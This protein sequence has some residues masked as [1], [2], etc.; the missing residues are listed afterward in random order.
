MKKIRALALAMALFA[1]LLAR[2]ALAALPGLAESVVVVDKKANQIH[3]ANY[4]E[5]RLDVLKSYRATIGKNGGDKLWE[6]DLKTPEGIYDFLY[7]KTPPAL[8]KKFG[9]LAIY[10]GYPNSMDRHGSKTGFDI[11]LHGTDDPS[12]L[13]RPFDSLGCVVTDNVNV[14]EISDQIKLKDTKVIITKDFSP[15]RDSPRLA[16]AKEFFQHWLNS[17][18]GKDLAGYVESYAEEYKAEGR[19]RNDFAKYKDSLNKK[20]ETIKVTASD[21]RYYFHEKYD[22]VT[23]T[24]HYESTFAGGKPAY[25][26]NARKNLYLQER[27]GAYRIVTEENQ[28]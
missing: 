17:W 4:N 15:L 8:G 19:N 9:P 21:V 27:N 11:M 26:G 23:F 28:R 14:A 12:R 24:Q 5:G 13:E 2:P 25:A 1:A 16:L 3:L 6:G 10:I 7:R 18:S 20:Y 22:L